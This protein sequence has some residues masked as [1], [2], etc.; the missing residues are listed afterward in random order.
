[1]ISWLTLDGN[2]RQK[3]AYKGNSGN[4]ARI[5]T[6]QRIKIYFFSKQDVLHEAGD[7]APLRERLRTH[8]VFTKDKSFYL[9]YH[10]FS[11]KSYNVAVY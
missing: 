7:R 8:K 2:I 6:K 5:F 3:L 1:M 11:I 9:N 10:K 4:F